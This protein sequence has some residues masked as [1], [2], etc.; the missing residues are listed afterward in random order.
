MENILP[1]FEIPQTVTDLKIQAYD[2][3]LPLLR[4][5][6]C[7]TSLRG[8]VR[9]IQWNEGD[10]KFPTNLTSLKMAFSGGSDVSVFRLF[11]VIGSTIQR[12]SLPAVY[13]SPTARIDWTALSELSNLKYF[14]CAV[15]GL[16]ST[17]EAS[18]LPRSLDELILSGIEPPTDEWCVEIIKALPTKLRR[19]EGIWPTELSAHVLQ[20]LP[21]T[22]EK[23]EHHDIKPEMVKYLPDSFTWLDLEF[24]DP[25]GI[26]SFPTNLRHL[27][28]YQIPDS[29]IEKLPTQLQTLK[30]RDISISSE[31]VAKLPRHLT[32]LDSYSSVPMVA[33]MEPLFAAL[34]PSLTS[35]YACPPEFGPD[36]PHPTPSKSSRL[37]PRGMKELGIGCLDFSESSIAEWTLELPPALTHLKLNVHQLQQGFFASLGFLSSLDLLEV[38]SNNSPTEGWANHLKFCHLPRNLTTMKLLDHSLAVGSRTDITNDAFKG[39]PSGLIRITIPVSPLVSKDC[40]VHLPNLCDFWVYPQ[41]RT[42][43]WFDAE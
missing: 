33:A 17:V 36:V 38:I 41:F 21:K 22:L 31:I 27:N 4:L 35:F 12:I 43:E 28:I 23:L 15:G 24:A 29:V 1:E 10:T 11:P 6:P 39:A 3:I 5:P 13:G 25:E 16:F 40:L 42:I 37:L 32:H 8:C 9:S 30:I 26:S 2:L 14:K 34:P 7:L 20:H 18:L 19:L